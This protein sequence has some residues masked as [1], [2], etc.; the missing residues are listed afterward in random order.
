MH[1]SFYRFREDANEWLKVIGTFTQL[2]YLHFERVPKN[3]NH[4]RFESL[5]LQLD[6]FALR[7]LTN[8][9]NL[10]ELSV[11]WLHPGKSAG[12]AQLVHLP[13]ENLSLENW[14]AG[15]VGIAMAIGRM[16]RLKKLEFSASKE[17]FRYLSTLRDLQ[18]LKTLNMDYF[19]AQE[20]M[21]IAH[22]PLE[23]LDISGC[24]SFLEDDMFKL[25]STM[26]TLQTVSMYGCK[27]NDDNIQRLQLALPKV[28]VNGRKLKDRR[29]RKKRKR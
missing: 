20:L 5:F 24:T 7:N 19:S 17:C 4:I 23:L 14:S 25:L 29:G 3:N 21:Y 16:K 28:N 2:T 10:R 13:I 11:K 8:L 1:V 15:S 27:F 26:K 12:I 22:L 18:E 6:D 9:V